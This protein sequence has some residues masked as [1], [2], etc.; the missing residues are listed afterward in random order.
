MIIS[1]NVN[2]ISKL[3]LKNRNKRAVDYIWLL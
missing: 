1:L 3:I 2:N